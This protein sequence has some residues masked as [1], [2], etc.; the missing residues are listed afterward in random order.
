MKIDLHIHSNSSDGVFSVIHHRHD[1]AVRTDIKQSFYV[2]GVI[3]L[4]PHYG[5]ALG[6]I[7]GLHHPLQRLIVHRPVFIVEIEKIIA[8]AG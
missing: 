2:R 5:G 6:A 1:N 4:D 8:N 3:F 7:H